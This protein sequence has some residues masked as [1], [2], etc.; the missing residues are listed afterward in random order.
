MKRSEHR[1]LFVCIVGLYPQE[2]MVD[3]QSYHSQSSTEQRKHINTHSLFLLKHLLS[4]RVSGI[5]VC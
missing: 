3:I 4:T 5:L 2:V 1:E